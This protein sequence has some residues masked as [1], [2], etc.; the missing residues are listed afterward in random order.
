MLFS[1]VGLLFLVL[2]LN[3][4]L[5]KEGVGFQMSS[6]A[7][8]MNLLSN[9]PRLALV[10]R[11]HAVL[12]KSCEL[13]LRETAQEGGSAIREALVYVV[14][15][16]NAQPNAS[17]YSPSQWLLGRQPHFPGDLLNPHLSPLHL[18]GSKGF[19][20]ELQKASFFAGCGKGCQECFGGWVSL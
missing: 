20:D 4:S 19:E 8:L 14:P 12:R 18:E 6:L 10:E 9:T 15:Q 2:L 17:G 3:S 5:T 1:V 16:L 11:R 13:Y 7:S